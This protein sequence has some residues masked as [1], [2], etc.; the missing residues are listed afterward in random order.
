MM[1]PGSLVCEPGWFGGGF[2]VP[3]YLLVGRV[4]VLSPGVV[5]GVAPGGCGVGGC[6][7]SGLLVDA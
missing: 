4:P 1:N 6:L 5:L 7:V 2:R 3:R